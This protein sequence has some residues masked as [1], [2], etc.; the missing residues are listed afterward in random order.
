MSALQKKSTAFRR[1]VRLLPLLISGAF[2]GVSAFAASTTTENWVPGR[3]LV[4]AKSGLPDPE[5]KKILKAHG[6]TPI[7]KI[8]GLNVFV[9]QLATKGSEKSV[10][11]LMS[12]NPHLKFAELDKYRPISGS[13]N[14]PSAG[15]QW[16]LSKIGA[17]AA[18]DIST[19]NGITIAIIDTGVDGSHPDLQPHIVAGWNFY[20]NNSDYSD[21]HGHGTAVAGTAAAAGNNGI[22]VASV[23]YNAKIMPLRVADSTGFATDSAIASALTWAAN[24]GA[25]VANISFDGV[26]G[27]STILNA[28]KYM[29]GK[30]GLTVVAAGNSGTSQSISPTDLVVTVSATDSADN[31]AS[32]SSYGSYVDIAAPGTYILTTNRGGGYGQWQGTSFSSPVVAGA[33]A[34]VMASNPALPNTQVEN[35]LLSTAT[36]LGSAGKDVFFGWGRVNVAAAAQAAVVAVASDTTPPTVSITSPGDGGIVK[37]IVNVSVSASDNVGV[38]RVDLMVNGVPVGSDNMAPHGFSWDSSTIADGPVTITAYAYDAAGN[39]SSSSIAATV[40]NVVDTIAPTATITNPGNGSTV[41]NTVGI[42]GVGSDNIAVMNAKLYID[43][44]LVASSSGSS[45]SYNWNS[46]KASSGTHTV[47]LDVSDAAG[48]VGSTT[49]Q[50]SK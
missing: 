34:T 22:G 44:K 3:L 28:A 25:R 18:W 36:D 30:D 45:V 15:G 19:G 7:G 47:R 26:T 29:K 31:L 48:N 13:V 40:S 50:V 14:D 9:V 41:K 8:D 33:V 23:A 11:A 35:A 38:D 20:N 43:G 24:N 39:Y 37:G 46:R 1:T 49:V 42:Q 6:A 12:K 5:F 4:Q 16:H 10:A 17:P 2:A 32:F 27:S 21:V